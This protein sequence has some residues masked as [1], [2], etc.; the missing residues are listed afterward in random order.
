R[1]PARQASRL[2]R[3]ASLANWLYTVALRLARQAR[4]SETRRAVRDRSLPPRPASS[5]PWAD[6]SGRELLGIIDEELTALP[7]RYRLPLLLCGLDGLARDEAAARLHWTVD[8]LRGRLER[9]RAML[10]QRLTDR[11]LTVPV[12]LTAGLL[13]AADSA[14]AVPADLVATVSRAAL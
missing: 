13:T 4:I 10:R 11:G 1:A 8:A 12:T 7:E 2:G 6:V 9:G 3:P 14:A 5:D